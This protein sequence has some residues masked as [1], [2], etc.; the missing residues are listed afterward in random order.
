MHIMLLFDGKSEIAQRGVLI[1][2]TVAASKIPHL[3]SKYFLP[4]DSFINEIKKKKIYSDYEKQK[5]LVIHF[6]AIYQTRYKQ[7]LDLVGLLNH[8]SHILRSI[9][10]LRIRVILS[11]YIKYF[12][13]FIFKTFEKGFAMKFNSGFKNA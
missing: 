11:Y 6:F 1:F 9:F 3:L 2:F 13:L 8:S 7:I 4:T 10:V 5:S 12:S